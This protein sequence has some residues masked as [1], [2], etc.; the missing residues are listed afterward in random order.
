ME[1]T[2]LDLMV[3]KDQISFDFE[4]IEEQSSILPNTLIKVLNHDY[5]ANEVLY[6]VA[7]VKGEEIC[8]HFNE[9]NLSGKTMLEWTL[10]A[11][12]DCEQKI[13]DEGD[14]IARL[15]Q[16]ETDKPIIALFFS[17]T[18]LFDKK[19]FQEI[20]DYFSQRGMNYL[21]LNRGLIIKTSYLSRVCGEL[22]GDVAFECKNLF[23]VDDAKKINL[24]NS[25]LQ[26]K[27]LAYHKKNGVIMLGD[28]VY[29]EADCEIEKGT[30]VY[31]NNTILGQSVIESG[32]I[33]ESGNV[34]KD[35]IVCKNVTLKGCYIEKSKITSSPEPL[36][37]IINQ[38]V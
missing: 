6:V 36:S 31:P 1:T 38:K 12:N 15:K 2:E 18:P 32:S 5:I 20:I 8:P 3:S 29:I 10:M 14:E 24:V 30:V 25:I 27:I 13:I 19:S 34:V 17:D 28:N 7:K 37:K 11:G 23:R 9:L 16:I 4:A 22:V 26:E 21:R 33:L 35:S